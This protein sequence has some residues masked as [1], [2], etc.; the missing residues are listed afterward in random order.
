[1]PRACGMAAYVRDEYGAFRQ[2]KFTLA[3]AKSLYLGFVVSDRTSMCLV[4]IATLTK[5][6]GFM[7]VY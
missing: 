4:C 7:N 3:G 1:M 5:M 2:A 6:I